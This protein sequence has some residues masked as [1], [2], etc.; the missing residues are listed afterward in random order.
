MTEERR[1][2]RQEK[3]RIRDLEEWSNTPAVNPYYQGATP[4]DVARA[5]LRPDARKGTTP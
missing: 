2:K 1:T 5:L 3:K 4:R